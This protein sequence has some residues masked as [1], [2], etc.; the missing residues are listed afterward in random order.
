MTAPAV[1]PMA[2]VPNVV[3]QIEE[4]QPMAPDAAGTGVGDGDADGAGVGQGTGVG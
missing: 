1:S 4:S 3:T 2:N